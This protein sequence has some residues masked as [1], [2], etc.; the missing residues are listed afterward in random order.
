MPKEPEDKE[1]KVV[2]EYLQ[3][4]QEGVQYSLDLHSSLLQIVGDF[5]HDQGHAW[6]RLMDSLG[7]LAVAGDD[8][9]SPYLTVVPDEDEE[10]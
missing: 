2:G 8:D 5:A 1:I 9:D 6:D 7:N 10:G 3:F 4:L